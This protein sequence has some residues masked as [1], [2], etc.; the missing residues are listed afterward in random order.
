MI[1]LTKQTT[2]STA[3]DEVRPLIKVNKPIEVP[4]RN[5][6]TKVVELSEIS[7]ER[8]SVMNDAPE[9]SARAFVK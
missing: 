3:P 9:D 7:E 1:P 2:G 5:P 8:K 4:S 6:S